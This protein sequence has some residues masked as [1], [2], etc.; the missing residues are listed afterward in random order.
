MGGRASPFAAVGAGKTNSVT[1]TVEEGDV[2]F[3]YRPRPPA[4][5]EWALPLQIPGERPTEPLERG[6]LR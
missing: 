2:F 5:A 3:L 4:R 6:E 1:R